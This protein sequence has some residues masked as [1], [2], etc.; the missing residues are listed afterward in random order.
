[1]ACKY[2]RINPE[3]LP[4]KAGRGTFRD[5]CPSSNREFASMEIIPEECVVPAQVRPG[6]IF[7]IK[8]VYRFC[9]EEDRC[10]GLHFSGNPIDGPPL[11]NWPGYHGGW[12]YCDQGL[13]GTCVHHKFWI[14]FFMHMRAYHNGVQVAQHG[15]AALSPGDKFTYTWQGTIEELTG[16]EFTEPSK[17]IDHFTLTAYVYGYYGEEKWPWGWPLGPN[18]LMECRVEGMNT[19]INVDVPVPPPP[20][21]PPYPLFDTD[22][23]SVSKST[24]EPTESFNINLRLANQNE[25]EG[26]YSIGCFCEGKYQDLATGNIAGGGTKDLTIPVTANKLAQRQITEDQYLG[27]TITV[28]NEEQETDRWTPAAI[29]VLAGAEPDTADLS[30]TVKDKATGAALAGV[31]VAADGVSTK[32]NSYGQYELTNLD[33]GS[34][35]IIFTRAGY[36][37]ATKSKRLYVGD[38]VLN[39]QMTPETE[40]EPSGVPW[41][42]IAAAGAGIAGL[43]II[44]PRL[45]RASKEK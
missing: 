45:K 39:V 2:A 44:I 42:L 13:P 34:Y 11:D 30:G 28:N 7:Q 41:G 3:L 18:W 16:V 21:L 20:P 19:T 27:F 10:G 33:P 32:T 38:N 14:W 40:P 5:K 17:V 9:Q 24:V 29:A 22:Y 6:E 35:T 12:R 31:A 25:H 43:L 37:Q 36:W 15:R 26:P 1:M 8:Y 4:L 23:C